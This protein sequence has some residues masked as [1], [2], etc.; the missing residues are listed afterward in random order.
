MVLFLSYGYDANQMLENSVETF[1]GKLNL[2]FRSLYLNDLHDIQKVSDEI[3]ASFLFIELKKFH[4]TLILKTLKNCRNLRIP[5]VICH[6]KYGEMKFQNLLMPVHFLVEEKGKAQYASALAR[7]CDT[8]ITLLQANDY[9]SRAST[10]V[11][12]ILEILAKLEVN[13]QVIKAQKDSFKVDK[14]AVAMAHTNF[15]CLILSASREYAL[16][17]VIFGPPEL[18]NT[19]ISPVPIIWVNPRGDL[20]A[21]CD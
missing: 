14:E 16:D 11:N 15:D 17:D 12:Q 3:E 6:A 21:L 18:K 1:S 7:F 10:H 13:A 2:P 8:N 4:S 5:Y 9:G 19:K 20:F